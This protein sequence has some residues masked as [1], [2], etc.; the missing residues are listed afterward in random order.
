MLV[1]AQ[2]CAITAG[3]NSGLVKKG[4]M[5]GSKKT[6]SV[7][8]RIHFHSQRRRFADP[9]GLSGKAVI[10]GLVHFGILEDD[11]A[12]FVSEVRFTQSKVPKG[13]PEKTVVVIEAV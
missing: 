1:G 12:Q 9:D 13:E 7:P 2:P 8:V 6:F 11:S 4:E 5:V 3:L 10:D